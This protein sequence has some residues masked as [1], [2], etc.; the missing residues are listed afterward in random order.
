MVVDAVEMKASCRSSRSAGKALAQIAQAS[1]ASPRPL[2]NH[3]HHACHP[4]RTAMEGQSFARNHNLPE[5]CNFCDTIVRLCL[6]LPPDSGMDRRNLP[7]TCFINGLVVAWMRLKKK[8]DER[9]ERD[10]ITYSTPILVWSSV[11]LHEPKSSQQ[12]R[13]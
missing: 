5:D 3:Q 10:F 8:Y 4:S 12:K 7:N 2:Q 9:V 1:V 6:L 13:D 11:A